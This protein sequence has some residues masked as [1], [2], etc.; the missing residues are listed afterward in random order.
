MFQTYFISNNSS[1]VI[2]IYPESWCGQSRK[3]SLLNSVSI[4]RNRVQ[5]TQFLYME[6][7]FVELDFYVSS[8]LMVTWV[9]SWKSSLLDSI[10]MNGPQPSTCCRGSQL[11]PVFLLVCLF[12]HYTLSSLTTFSVTLFT[13][14]THLR[15]LHKIL[16]LFAIFFFFKEKFRTH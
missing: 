16:W 11:G 2:S 3:P 7:E 14:Y 8:H 9:L 12:T 10:S 13:H 15:Y 6:T 4:H 1:P 5:W